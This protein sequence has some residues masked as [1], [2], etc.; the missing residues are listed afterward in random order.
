MSCNCKRARE[1]EEEY[2]E[3]Q[4][5]NFFWRTYRFLWRIIFSLIFVILGIII[6]P[7]IILMVLYNIVFGR[8]NILVLPKQL[9]KYLN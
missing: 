8:E 6:T 4:K 7:I 2:G 5:E 3:E 1:I 9:R